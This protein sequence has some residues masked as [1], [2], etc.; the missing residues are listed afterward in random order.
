MPGG[1]PTETWSNAEA[2]DAFVGRWSRLVATEL[3]AWVAV[4]TGRRWLDLGCGSGA[5]TE[6]ILRL[7][8][9]AGVVGVDP[10]EAFIEHDRA[11]IED[12]RA[13][14]EVG[15]AQAIPLS[16]GTFDAVV[17]GLVLNFVP[18]PPRALAE[19]TRVAGVGGVV[20]AYVWDYADGMEPLRR[21]W[22][23]AV[24]LDP[25]AADL[26]E[27]RRFPLCAPEP[28][29]RVFG[30]AGLTGVAT[31]AIELPTVFR[32]FDDF[33][34]P[35]LSGQGPAP[36]YAMSLEEDRRAALRDR[37]RSTLP[38]EPDGSIRLRARAWAV[39]GVSP[40]RPD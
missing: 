5:L 22:D 34:E 4:P 19:M 7:A 3:L 24:E 28:L 38:A 25:A 13:R 1:R 12:I 30:E 36:V 6:T 2:Y 29:A 27:A 37:L 26:D 32:D 14:F 16:D 39:K 40:S 8:D 23:A 31:R 18:D 33:W 21:F 9:P 15:D 20:A 11:R 35:F 17:A 10:S